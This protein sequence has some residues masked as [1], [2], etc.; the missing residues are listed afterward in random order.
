M[1]ADSEGVEGK[2]F[3]WTPDEVRALV[4]A[5]AAAVAE[6]CWDIVP[7][8]NWQDPHGHGPSGASILHV[9]DRPRDDREVALL[10]EAKQT[11]LAA[12][13]K[14]IP[15]GTDDK[16]LAS[17]N[18]LALAGLAEAGRILN[19]SALVDGARRTAEFLLAKMRD[20]SGRLLRTYKGGVAKLP[21][22]LEDHAWV[23]D[24]LIALYEATGEGRWLEEAH[25]LT[26]LALEL[27]WDPQERAFY[28]TAAADPG[29][30]Q[31]PLS[32][33]DGAVPSGMSVCVEN[34]VRLGDLCGER[35]WLDVAEAA[36]RVHHQAALSSPFAFSNL[37]CALDLYQER[38]AEIVLAGDDTRPLERAVASVY[39]PNRVI[40]RAASAPSL[41]APLL[42]GKGPL[43]GR[44]AAW[45]CRDFACERPE[46]DPERLAASLR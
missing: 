20:P 31:R 5:E 29:L 33:H 44:S 2:Y 35:A 34:L 46:T 25:R 37:V 6:R 28:I 30:I 1:D 12:R 41:I 27:F 42:A 14:R 38:P 39:L 8:G 3:V 32:S 18:G 24:G 9:V 19:E 13:A 16:V 26:R 17:S 22:T 7:G 23:A 21:G 11:L 45:V 36:L 43:D 40:V 15:P 4:G 10:A